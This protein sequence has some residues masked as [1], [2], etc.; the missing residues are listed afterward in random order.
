M[1]TNVPTAP[2]QPGE[3]TVAGPSAS[4]TVANLARISAWYLAAPPDASPKSEPQ[5]IV[6]ARL[7]V[8]TAIGQ[9]TK[10]LAR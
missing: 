3:L 4:T 9:G 8:M 6:A 7:S 1:A 2:A 5:E 10:P